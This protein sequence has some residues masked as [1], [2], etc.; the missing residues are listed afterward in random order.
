VMLYWQLPIFVIGL[1]GA[2][3]LVADLV[4]IVILWSSLNLGVDLGIWCEPRI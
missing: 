1:I 3:I 4:V 2:I